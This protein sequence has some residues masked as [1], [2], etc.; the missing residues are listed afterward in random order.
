MLT[1]SDVSDTNAITFTFSEPMVTFEID[2][3]NITEYEFNMTGPLAPYE[4]TYEVEF[5]DEYTLVFN[6]TQFSQ[7]QGD[8]QE[9]LSISFNRSSFQSVDG[10]RLYNTDL[11]TS[12]SKVPILPDYVATLGTSMNSIMTVS[13]VTMISSNVILGGS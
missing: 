12:L 9:K 5:T 4:Y 2:L 11:E 10:T 7:M 3:D 8:D 6:I 1:I 13:M